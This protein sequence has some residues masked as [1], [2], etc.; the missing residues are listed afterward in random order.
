MCFDQIKQLEVF[1][2]FVKI[3][4]RIKIL[5]LISTAVTIV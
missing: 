4:H 2:I 5:I 3:I 1:I